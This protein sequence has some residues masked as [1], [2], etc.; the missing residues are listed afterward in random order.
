MSVPTSSP[1]Q[2][3]ANFDD[4]VRR[5]STASD[6]R[7]HYDVEER[8]AA[9]T[10]AFAPPP[11]RPSPDTYFRLDNPPPTGLVCRNPKCRSEKVVWWQRQLS[12][13]DEGMRAFYMCTVCFREWSKK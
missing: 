13:G 8:R 3:S 2:T 9:L 6:R 11:P 4:E 5:G 7:L 1:S 12:S 10:A